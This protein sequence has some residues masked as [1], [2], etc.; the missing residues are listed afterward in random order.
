MIVP[1]RE[2]QGAGARAMAG[3]KEGMAVEEVMAVGKGLGVVAA[4]MIVADAMTR[5]GWLMLRGPGIGTC[6][7]WWQ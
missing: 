5:F 4:M 6:G 1:R 3:V 7:M 2:A